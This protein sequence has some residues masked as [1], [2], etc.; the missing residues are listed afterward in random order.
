MGAWTNF[1]TRTLLQPV[2]LIKALVQ[3]PDSFINEEPS[4]SS[5]PG[6]KASL[7]AASGKATNGRRLA[8]SKALAASSSGWVQTDLS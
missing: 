2:F 7:A 8:A 1:A 5:A 3:L 4:R 6:A